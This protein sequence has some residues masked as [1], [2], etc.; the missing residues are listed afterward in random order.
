MDL[1]PDNDDAGHKH[2]D[3]VG[4][5]L[6]GVAASVRVLELPGLE[7]KQDIMDWAIAG[8]TVEQLHNLI[9]HKTRPW[10]PRADNTTDG[11]DVKKRRAPSLN[12]MCSMHGD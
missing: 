10:T 6:Q 1:I 8:G 11:G 12:P 2:C 5:S 7:P 3:I 9:T 4:A